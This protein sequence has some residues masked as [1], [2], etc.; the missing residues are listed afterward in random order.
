MNLRSII[1]CVCGMCI[2]ALWYDCACDLGELVVHAKD[3]I[4]L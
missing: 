3:E 4:R 1:H 2:F